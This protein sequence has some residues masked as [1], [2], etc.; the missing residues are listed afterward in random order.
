MLNGVQHNEKYPEA[1]RTFCLSQHFLSPRAYEALREYFNNKLPHPKTISAWYAMSDM[2]LQ[3]GVI[4]SCI[5]I[6]KQK[7]NE[8]KAAGKQLMVSLS[9]DEM[10]IRKLFQWCDQTK[11]IRGFPTFG[12]S[13][14]D[15]DKAASQVIVFMVNGVNEIFELPIAYHFITS[16]N[17]NQRY[18]LISQILDA[19]HE[20]QIKIT[21]IVFDGYSANKQMCTALGANL[22]IFSKDFQPYFVAKNGDLIWILFDIC[23]MEKL[24][25]NAIAKKHKL[26]DEFGQEIDWELFEYL[27]KFKERGFALTHKLN[28]RHLDWNRR[29]M[30]VN[31]AT[32]V[33]SAS[34][35]NS[36]EFLM[37]EGYAEFE[38]AAPT[39]RIC[40]IFDEVFDCFN[41]KPEKYNS[42]KEFKNPLCA[43]NHEKMFELFHRAI[44]YIKRLSF[45]STK[46]NDILLVK[47]TLKT[48]FVGYIINMHSLMQMYDEFV[49]KK[50]YLSSI[51]TYCLNQDPLEIFFGKSRS[52]NGHNDNPSIQ[53]LIVNDTICTSKYANCY[54]FNLASK[55]L[56]NILFVSSRRAKIKEN[57]NNG[58]DDIDDNEI[59]PDDLADLHAKIHQIEEQECNALTD[60]HLKETTTMHIANV[61]ESRF[62]QPFRMKC[63]LCQNVFDENRKVGRAFLFSKKVPCESTFIICNTADRLLK[64]ELLKDNSNFKTIYYAIF[65]EI[66][67]ENLFTETD[68]KHN[69][70]HKLFLIRGIIDVF[71]QIKGT[72]LAKTATLDL[73]KNQLRSRL[74]K[75]I[76][77]YGQ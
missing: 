8:F 71:V 65:Q 13:P 70:V 62:K 52:L 7:A 1:V 14:G 58:D 5:D 39:I 55:P 9:F 44:E 37:H 46:G 38:N 34:T 27:V 23:H 31:L 18:E 75:L 61:I 60:Q 40:R 29:K 17:G 77:F 67:F 6:L 22:D 66:D 30:K 24:I 41:S 15:E 48:G 42:E 69:S 32:E 63:S 10:H 50:K 33:L 25:R 57:N 73:H 51:P 47:S 36:L 16:L 11:K 4:N 21:N 19:L 72:Y 54:N 20:A 68:F 2:R 3:P 56:S 45:V 76:H 74:K 53:R 64:Y 26:Y 43:N 59:I 12:V 35:A 28:R 49:V